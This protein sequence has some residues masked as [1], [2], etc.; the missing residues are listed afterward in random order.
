MTGPFNPQWHYEGFPEPGA[1]PANMAGV[2][3]ALTWLDEHI[4]PPL[5]TVFGNIDTSGDVRLFWYGIE[6]PVIE[7]PHI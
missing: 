4:T 6:L 5:G 7:P 3:A 2:N 1:G